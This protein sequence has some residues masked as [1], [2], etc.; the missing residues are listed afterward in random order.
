MNSK[1]FKRDD[2]AKLYE[3]RWG[4]LTS[5]KWGEQFTK[6][7]KF[8]H[9][10]FMPQTFIIVERGRSSGWGTQSHKDIL[11]EYLSGVAERDPGSL[12]KLA[13]NLKKQTRSFL[14][15]LENNKHSLPS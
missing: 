10:P 6:E 2:W 9:L 13:N 14:R 4:I 3:G 15:F 5:S 12:K 11:G 1:N 8:G 7:I